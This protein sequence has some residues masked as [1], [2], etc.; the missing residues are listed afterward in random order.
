MDLRDNQTQDIFHLEVDEIAKS[1]MLEMSRWTKFMAILGFIAI[2]IFI[3]F[4]FFLVLGASSLPMY[5]STFT[6][7]NSIGIAIYF[8]VV[9]AL[10]FYPIYALIKYST[11]IKSALHT[12]NQEQ[13]NTALKYLK[14]MFKYMGIMAIIA[15]AFYGL[16]IILIG[17]G[18]AMR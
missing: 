4:A 8:V 13:F 16:A 6:S 7:L 2:G 5:N 1:T 3:V 12:A 11:N 10:E 14:N 9:A 15:L 18:T 17:I